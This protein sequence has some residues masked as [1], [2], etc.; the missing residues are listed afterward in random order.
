[1]NIDLFPAEI[2]AALPIVTARSSVSYCLG[3]DVA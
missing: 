1:L 3:L 2:A